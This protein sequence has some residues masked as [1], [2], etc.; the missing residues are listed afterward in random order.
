MEHRLEEMPALLTVSQAQPFLRPL[1]RNGVYEAARRNEIPHI[2]IG[3]RL[4]IPRE[5]LRR[6]LDG[7]ATQSDRSSCGRNASPWSAP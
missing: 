4:L 3:R 7:Q 1:G 6:L 2:R 5:G